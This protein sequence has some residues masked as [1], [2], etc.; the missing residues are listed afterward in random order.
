MCNLYIPHCTHILSVTCKSTKFIAF[1]PVYIK[2]Y[3]YQLMHL[4]LSYTTAVAHA[5]TQNT[6][7]KH[8][9]MLPHNNIAVFINILN[10][11]SVE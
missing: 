8:K 10:I 2:F 6:S 11:L 9:H 7:Q 1:H 5:S 3:S 4:F